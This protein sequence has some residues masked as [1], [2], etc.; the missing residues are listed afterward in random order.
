MHSAPHYQPAVSP[1]GGLT[2][3][4]LSALSAADTLL[5]STLECLQAQ[6]YLVV[7]RLGLCCPCGQLMYLLPARTPLQC[8]YLPGEMHRGQGREEL[9][10]ARLSVLP[11]HCATDAWNKAFT[12]LL[13]KITQIKDKSCGSLWQPVKNA[14]ERSRPHS[15]VTDLSGAIKTK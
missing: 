6:L 14:A 13:L 15:S 2:Y 12:L 9:P 11:P 5:S 4:W 1:G 3:A 7:S 8:L 10:M